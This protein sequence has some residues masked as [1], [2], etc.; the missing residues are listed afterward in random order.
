MQ[1]LANIEPTIELQL[2]IDELKKQGC[3]FDEFFLEAVD[4]AFSMLG[5]H[6]KELMYRY[7]ENKCGV[8]KEN[9]PHKV[10]LFSQTIEAIFGQSSKIIEMKIMRTLHEKVPTFIYSEKK[11]SNLSFVNYVEA[12]RLFL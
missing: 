6:S 12:F 10:D 9:I 5:N 11:A 3:N 1:Q 4:K 2:N 7:L 8:D